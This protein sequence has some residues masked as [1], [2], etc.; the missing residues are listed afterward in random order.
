MLSERLEPANEATK[1]VSENIGV[2]S[3]YMEVPSID[4]LTPLEAAAISCVLKE[5]LERLATVEFMIPVKV[6]PRWDDTFKTIDE[7]YGIPD[8]P[9]KIFREDMGLLPLIP[10]KSQKLQR[11]R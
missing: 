6:D 8:E 2:Q 11:D 3:M 9:R 7:T 4:S 1:E 5:C 10:T